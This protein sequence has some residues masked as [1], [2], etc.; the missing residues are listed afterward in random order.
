M[1]ADESEVVEDEASRWRGRPGWL[2]RS[3]EASRETRTSS[4]ID[5]MACG[6]RF[7]M[8]ELWSRSGD[9][10]LLARGGQERA[11]EIAAVCAAMRLGRSLVPR[12]ESR[13]LRYWVGTATHALARGSLV[14]TDVDRG[15]SSVRRR[16]KES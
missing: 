7:S 14:F 13:V 9:D 8:G 4:P 10:D 12:G 6:S 15:A 2:C 3:L 1:V 5:C 16:G 11:Y